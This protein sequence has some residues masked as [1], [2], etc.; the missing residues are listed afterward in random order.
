MK[1]FLAKLAISLVA[2]A[3]VV[4]SAAVQPALAAPDS[5]Q[6]LAQLNRQLSD[7]QAKLEQLNN[8]VE[9]AQSDVDALNHRLGEDQQRESELRK[10]LSVLARLEYEQP[11][12]T[13]STIL[14]A[15]T[16]DQ[17]LSNIAQARLVAEKQRRL[18]GQAEQLRRQDQRA[19]EK[20]AADVAKIKAARDDAALVATS[21]LDLRNTTSD[22]ITKAR[23]EAIATQAR[24][25][26]AKPVQT[27]APPRPAPPP[28]PPPPPSSGP[29]PPGAIVE[30][31]GP[32]HFA[33]GYCTWYVA[34][35]R[36]V[37]WFGNAIEWWANA[38]PY[39]YR[40]GQTPVVGAIM[41]TR[42]SGY[43]HVAYV[44]AVNGDGSWTVS[45]MNYKGWNIVSRRTIRAGQVPLS[46]FIYGKG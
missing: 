13:L 2:A 28:P 39:G 22:E 10:Q 30:A 15:V 32:N 37:P 35:K 36:N 23:A 9:T 43:G 17:L 3:L 29:P 12:L 1:R 25:T 14:D 16:L 5:S 21:T 38:R 46:G 33:Y 41:V 11:A 7:A 26:Q 6:Q 44:E 34:N 31:P 8:S 42:E 4:P 19:A 40:E 27:P 20:R 18:K 45:E 24:A